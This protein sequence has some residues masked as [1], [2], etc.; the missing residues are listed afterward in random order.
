MK[1]LLTEAKIGAERALASLMQHHAEAA[2][3][4]EWAGQILSV[5]NSQWYG[6]VELS[7]VNRST[8]PTVSTNV[9]EL[10]PGVEYTW[11][12]FSYGIQMTNY[13]CPQAEQDVCH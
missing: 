10:Q 9:Q 13:V 12:R 7:P 3:L 8:T 6:G 11:V 2:K 4:D 1:V 5:G